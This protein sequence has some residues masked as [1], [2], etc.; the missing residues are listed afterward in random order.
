MCNHE[1]ILQ[2][3]TKWVQRSGDAKHFWVILINGELN[4]GVNEWQ[5]RFSSLRKMYSGAILSKPSRLNRVITDQLDFLRPL[6]G[7]KNFLKIDMKLCQLIQRRKALYDTATRNGTNARRI[8][9]LWTKICTEMNM[10]FNMNRSKWEPEQFNHF[11]QLKCDPL[12]F[13]EC[14]SEW[15]ED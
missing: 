6:I 10:T 1:H 12:L 8:N 3:E 4:S 7:T 5:M 13:V 9:K 14:R 2:I 15:L 11:S